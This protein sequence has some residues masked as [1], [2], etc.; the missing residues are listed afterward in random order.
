MK[1][2]KVI[3]EVLFILVTFTSTFFSKSISTRV[4]SSVLMILYLVISRMRLLKK[5][6]KVINELN[7]NGEVYIECKENNYYFLISIN[8]IIFSA[9][10][11]DSIINSKNKLNGFVDFLNQISSDEKGLIFVYFIVIIIAIMMVIEGFRSIAIISD[12]KIFFYDDIKFEFS[13]ITKIK[14]KEALFSNKKIIKLCTKYD[15]KHIIPKVK[16]FER[17]KDFLEEKVQGR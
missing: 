9:S 8:L 10:N 12:N 16:D 4:L 14:Y 3:A 1:K 13:E 17:I 5:R 7:N 15:E 11:I 2:L 6:K